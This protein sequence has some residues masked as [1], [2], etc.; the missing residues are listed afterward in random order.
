MRALSMLFSLGIVLLFAGGA[1]VLW[2]INHYRKDL[3]PYEQLADY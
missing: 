2:G 1:V 3:P